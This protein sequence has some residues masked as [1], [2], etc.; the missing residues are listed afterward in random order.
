MSAI[1]ITGVLDQS[2]AVGTASVGSTADLAQ[3]FTA[4]KSGLLTAVRLW[5][6][7]S[8]ADPLSVAIEGTTAGE[9]DGSPLAFS[10]SATP[11]SEPGWVTF[12][13]PYPIPLS[14]GTTYAM[15]FNTNQTGADAAWGSGDTYSGG[16]AM[17]YIGGLGPPSPQT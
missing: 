6:N 5:M 13:F 17:T 4:G 11:A 14:A 10:Y 1:P 16:Q 7:G 9:P 8:G 3:T 2:N 15:V 12:S